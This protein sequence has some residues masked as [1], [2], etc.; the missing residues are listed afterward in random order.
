M[1][2]STCVPWGILVCFSIQENHPVFLFV[3]CCFDIYT[4]KKH[5]IMIT[6]TSDD[7]SLDDKTVVSYKPVY[8]INYPHKSLVIS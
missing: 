7:L 4:L 2:E 8:D 6:N 5:S 3:E 1:T